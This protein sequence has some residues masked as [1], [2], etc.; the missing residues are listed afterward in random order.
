MA[1]KRGAATRERVLGEVELTGART[2]GLGRRSRWLTTAVVVVVAGLVA[3]VVA[4]LGG[5]ESILWPAAA[6]SASG[7]ALNVGLLK[8]LGRIERTQST[9]A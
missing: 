8:Y 4:W 3:L 9:D 5:D 2:G 7:L 6:V 1:R